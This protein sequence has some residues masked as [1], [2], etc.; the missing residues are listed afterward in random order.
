MVDPSRSEEE[1]RLAVLDSYNILD[2]PAEEGFDDI[3][4]LAAQICATPVALVSLVANDRQWFK[5]RVGFDPHQTPIN[6]SVCQ[7]ALKQPGL[8]IIPDL[9]LDDRTSTNP[10]VTGEPHLRFYAGA[11]LETAE[12]VPLGTLC[13]IDSVPRPNGLSQMQASGLKALARQ[14]MSQLELRRSIAALETAEQAVKD[15]NA[16]HHQILESAVDF[17]IVA[18]D[19]VGL[20]TEWNSGATRIFGWSCEEMKGQPADLFFTPEDRARDLVQQEMRRSLETGRA[21]D[22]RWHMKKDGSRFWANGEMMPLRT[23]AGQHIGFIKIVRDETLRRAAAEKL[24]LSEEFLQGVLASS[25]DCIQVLDLDGALVFMSERGQD[26]MDVSDFDAIRGRP[27]PVICPYDL[28][29]TAENALA[30]ARTGG[31]GHYQGPTATFAGI[32]KWWDVRIT[33]I[34]DA[35]GQIE[36]LLAVS[37]DITASKQAERELQQSQERLN[38]ALGASGMVGIWDWDLKADIIY[39]DANFAH[40]YTV[41]PAWAARGAPLSEFTRNFHPDDLPAFQNELDRLFSGADEFSNEYR[42]FQPDGS[43]RWV[44]ARGRIVRDADG[45]PIR[46][47]GAS[48][49]ITERKQ[50]EERRLAILEL[51]DRLRDMSDT[52]EMAF[53]AS[54]IMGR[55]L[56]IGRAGYGAVNVAGEV[57]TIFRDWAKPNVAS[58]A[59]THSFRTFGS[60]VDDLKRGS[61]VVIDNTN[62]DDRTSGRTA[63]F[64]SIEVRAF[65][66]LPVIEHG[67]FVAMFFLHDTQPR[68]W[69][70]EQLAFARNVADRTRAAIERR[71]V[72][73]Q[74]RDLNIDLEQRVAERTRERDRVWRNS[75]DLL[76]IVDAEGQFRAVNPAAETILGWTPDEMLGLS[77]FDFIHPDD[78]GDASE[79]LERANR[80]GLR[81]YI[82]RFRRKDGGYRWMS[83]VAAPEDG[84]VYAYGRDITAEK[85]QAEALNLAEEQLRQSQKME[86][87][88]QLTGGVAHDFNNLLTVIR[89]SID[90]LKRPNLSDE[91]RQRYIDAISDTT[92]R[93]AKL[94]GQLLAFARRQALKPE[95]FDVVQSVGAISDMV[96]TLT[97][98]RVRVETIVHDEPCFV[99]AD[100]SQFETALVNLAV[101]ARDA[102]DGEG[103]LTIWVHP[104]SVLPALRAHP[105]VLGDFVAMSMTDSGSGIAP[106]D[107][108][109]IFEPFFTTKGVGKGTGL[110]L[111]QV[112]GF[113]KQSGGE[114]GVESILGEGT[115]FTLYLP[116]AVGDTMADES[117]N[118]ATMTVDGDGISVL[119]VEDNVD[120]GSFATQTLEELGYASVLAI[121]AKSALAELALDSSRFDVVFSD[122]V[123]P[124]MNGVDLAQEIRRRHADLP[125]VLTSGYS[126]VL[127]QSGTH[128]FELLHKPYSIEQ[129]SHVLTKAARMRRL[130]RAPSVAAES[131]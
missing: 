107:L 16:R 91:R 102:M 66:N 10:L 112:F 65:I 12:G 88:G 54:E 7:H 95:V 56:G 57:I 122:V 104:T 68:H 90:L 21:N 115:T 72:E 5:A 106:E 38:L 94:T 37:R 55:T 116:R 86:A 127:A 100:P 63:A 62:E 64:E 125:V 25:D 53:A 17:A 22:E 130:K 35:H 18:T 13:V 84:L 50:A 14:V 79:V 71:R 123:M 77:V 33:P 113:V 45:T 128:G 41:D 96:K 1:R 3:V 51:G 44:L 59:G 27:W 24:R 85:L 126:H 31:T 42:I 60:F 129:L 30:T 43:V 120:V 87:V 4:H 92:G 117:R 36:K 2:T 61:T 111:S 11:R 98:S 110:G 48:V 20:V 114:V 124:G 47:P 99:D 49:D 75:Q 9:T 23:E 82:N 118:G 83:W 109:R 121:D 101:N 108:D 78:L 119:L 6:Q 76:I 97:G 32:E 74:L 70:E 131:R 28:R 80:E 26:A 105:A 73:D 8:M 52:A 103:K 34:R 67:K 93:A 69:T 40:I 46:F 19:R 58:V 39:A 15:G 29:L 89:S 81:A